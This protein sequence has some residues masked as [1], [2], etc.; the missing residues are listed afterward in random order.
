MSIAPL[1]DPAYEPKHPPVG[2]RIPDVVA[3][4]GPR[5]QLRWFRRFRDQLTA[6]WDSYDYYS[7]TEHHRGGCCDSCMED[8]AAGYEDLPDVC[9]CYALR[10]EKQGQ[11]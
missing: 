7:E 9:C 3:K 6:Y 8:A 2:G 11:R 5:S 1:D 4:W 10:D